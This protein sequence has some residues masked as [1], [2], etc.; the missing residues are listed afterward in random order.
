MSEVQTRDGLYGYEFRD[1]DRRRVSSDERKTYDAKQLW[2]RNHEIVN[3]AAR[4]FKQTEIAEILNIHPQ[5]VS[6]TLNSTLG[7]HKLSELRQGRDEE[8]KKVSEK[9]RVLTD[10]ALK[11]YH[12]IFDDDSGE[13]SLRDKKDVADTVLLELSGLRSPTRIDSRHLSMSLTAQE[14]EEFKARGIKAAREAGLIVDIEPKA[15]EGPSV[16][17]VPSN[18]AS[19]S[20][21]QDRL[22]IEQTDEASK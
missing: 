16:A 15:V 19:Q 1:V 7:K 10:K 22:E 4:G 3:L 9:I 5:T 6:N 18:G 21:G 14:L 17:Q 12:E 20:D 13:A 8:A 2:Q 11:V